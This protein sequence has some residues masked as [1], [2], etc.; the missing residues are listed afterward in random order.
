MPFI[1]NAILR[2]LYETHAMT[3]RKGPAVQKSSDR[4]GWKKKKNARKNAKK[5]RKKNR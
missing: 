2:A 1:E 3:S 4:E 5:A